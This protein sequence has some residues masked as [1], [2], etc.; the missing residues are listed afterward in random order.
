MILVPE[1]LAK[2]VFIPEG[3]KWQIGSNWWLFTKQ[4]QLQFFGDTRE[5]THVCV[6]TITKS[7]QWS[8]EVIMS[9]STFERCQFSNNELWLLFWR[10]QNIL[11]HYISSCQRPI[12]KSWFMR[13][14]LKS[15][16]CSRCELMCV[17]KIW[18]FH[19]DKKCG[20]IHYLLRW[21]LQNDPKCV[22]QYHQK[23]SRG[24]WSESGSSDAD[25]FMEHCPK[26]VPITHVDCSPMDYLPGVQS[27]LPHCQ[28]QKDLEK[29]HSSLMWLK[30]SI[31]PG[32]NII[33][34]PIKYCVPTIKSQ[35]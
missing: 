25:L 4:L 21:P 29:S 35:V 19:L 32:R 15:L 18:P 3:K 2:F 6:R 31:F 26:N 24:G 9:S 5:R 28:P 13:S 20:T 14:F 30:S 10:S 8:V 27:N 22:T 1:E 11:S 12:W 16:N 7:Q 34:I 23:C 33:C 17:S